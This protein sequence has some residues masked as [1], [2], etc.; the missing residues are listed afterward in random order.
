MNERLTP[1]I[2]TYPVTLAVAILAIASAISPS[3][4]SLFELRFDLAADGQWWRWGSGHWTHYETSHLFWDLIMFGA[5]SASCERRHR[6][7]YAPAILISGVIISWAIAVFCPDIQ[8][9]RGLSGIDTSLFVWLVVDQMGSS[10]RK[11]RPLIAAASALAVLG[12]FGK[13]VFEASTGETLFVDSSTFIPLVESH[14][15]GAACGLVCGLIGMASHLRPVPEFTASACGIGDLHE[16]REERITQVD[17]E[18]FCHTL[19]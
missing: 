3:L 9:Y 4:T 7:W 13:L 8:Q 19:V 12:L 1:L 5:L 15:A 18:P 6:G 17:S 14:L 11:K 10:L 16:R 2:K